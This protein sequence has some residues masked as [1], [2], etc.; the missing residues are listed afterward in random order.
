MAK[1]VVQADAANVFLD[2]PIVGQTRI[3]L[4]SITYVV[5]TDE[6]II[7]YN[8][9]ALVIGSLNDYIESNSTTVILNFIPDAI[10]PD[11]DTFEFV[12][13]NVGASLFIPFPTTFLQ[14][15]PPK[16]PD[17]F[18]GRFTFP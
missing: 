6:L 7:F 11:V 4:G 9:S 15:D 14:V 18:G 12:T 2:D 10:G 1:E 13:V 17:N 5:G 16:R 8:G 3:V